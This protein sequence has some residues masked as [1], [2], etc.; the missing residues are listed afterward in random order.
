MYQKVR[1]QRIA[2]TQHYIYKAIDYARTA[3]EYLD[4]AYGVM[5]NETTA[6]EA[7]R[8]RKIFKSFSQK[9]TALKKSLRLNE[10]IIRMTAEWLDD[11]GEDRYFVY[12]KEVTEGEF[13]EEFMREGN[14]IIRKGFK[15]DEQ[16]KEVRKEATKTEMS[17]ENETADEEEST[18]EEAREE[19]EN[20]QLKLEDAADRIK[21][22][23][24]TLNPG[25]RERFKEALDRKGII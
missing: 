9:I 12:N 21:N 17:K 25:V 20:R 1:D 5:T 3:E 22:G 13:W 23:D 11:K 6:D 7:K 15:G 16:S 8:Y 4:I 18:E 10:E 24:I 14:E 2:A 19:A